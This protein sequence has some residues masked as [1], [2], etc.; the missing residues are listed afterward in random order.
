MKADVEDA[1]AV[2]KPGKGPAKAGATAQDRVWS[3]IVSWFWVIVAF[4]IIEGALVQARVIPSGSMEPT[5]L[6][7]DHLIV[8]RIGFDAGIPFTQYHVPL[9]REPKRQEIMVF[10]APLEDQGFPDFIKR[11]IGV[12]G[13]HIKIVQGTVFVN[14]VALKEPYTQHAVD[15]EDLPQE[16]YPARAGELPF[17]DRPEWAAE[18][19]QDTVNGELVVPK[20]EYFMMGDNRDDSNDSRFWGFVPR[21]DFIGTPLIIYMSI[22]APEEV[23]NPGHLGERFETYFLAI[24]HPSTIRWRR[25]FHTF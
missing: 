17:V 15:Y 20:D 11:V 18:L 3:E 25:L 19:A 9:W 12:P 23:W 14:G 24:V 4:L 5:V 8:S 16:N 21:E 2:E 22:K 13:D 1:V 6:I 7:G 10:R